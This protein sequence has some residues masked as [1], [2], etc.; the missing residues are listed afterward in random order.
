M[1]A[2]RALPPANLAAALQWLA[3]RPAPMPD[4]KTVPAPSP[5]T[6]SKP[7]RFPSR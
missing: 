1:F 3:K 7:A 6:P 5:S 2:W 4:K